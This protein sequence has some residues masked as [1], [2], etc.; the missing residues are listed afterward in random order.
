MVHIAYMVWWRLFEPQSNITGRYESLRNITIKLPT[1]CVCAV[2]PLSREKGYSH[3]SSAVTG[4]GETFRTA[5]CCE[6][7]VSLLPGGCEEEAHDMFYK[8]YGNLQGKQKLAGGLM[9][10]TL[11]YS[12]PH[13]LYGETHLLCA[14]LQQWG[15]KPGGYVDNH[16]PLFVRVPTND[17]MAE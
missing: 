12:Q 11:S 8:L 2:L 10:D 13:L 5:S 7:C 15:N 17:G 6:C 1:I 14:E 3:S 4:R 16:D 9:Q